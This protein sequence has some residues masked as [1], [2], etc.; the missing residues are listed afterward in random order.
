MKNFKVGKK[1][2]ISY[3]VIMIMLL[4]GFVISIVNLINIRNKVEEFCNGPFVVKSAAHIVN[5]SYESMLRALYRSLTTTDFTVVDE[6]ISEVNKARDTVEEQLNV[7]KKNFSGDQKIVE[8]LS[9]YLRE[10]KPMR[11]HV[12]ELA[13]VNANEEAA[14]YMQENNLIVIQNV[15]EELSKLVKSA[16]ESSDVLL[17]DLRAQQETALGVLSVLGVLSIGISALFAIYITRGV[18]RPIAE[19]EKAAKS[20]SDGELDAVITYDSKD[21]LGR[22]AKSIQITTSRLSVIMAEL[23]QVLKQIAEGN[24]NT[25]FQ[26]EDK[27]VGAFYPLLVSIKQASEELSL[28]MLQ[29]HQSAEQVLSGS[30]QV[31]SG[32]QEL[33]QGT[34]EQ[35]ASVEELAETVNEISEQINYNAENSAKASE[36]AGRVEEEV[37]KSNLRMQEMLEAMREI[38]RSSGEIQKIIKT[39]EDFAF[40]TNILALNASVEASRAGEAGKGFAVVADEVRTL[41]TKS[42]AASK[43]TAALIETSLQAVNA[44][45]QIADET[46]LSLKKVVTGVRNVTS[47][48][49]SVSQ[50]TGDQAASLQ[51]V[52]KGIEQISDVVQTNSATA[53]ESAAASEELSGQAQTLKALIGKFQLIG[54]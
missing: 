10:L 41:A 4:S 34:Y 7:I 36:Q 13:L 37:S 2:V 16:D 29:I 12:V 26:N 38:T 18:T 39:I 17:D 52:T 43:N 45:M 32:A 30:E 28:T 23:D 19:I 24:L 11:E 49:D 27:F 5:T 54:E 22:L 47:A 9:D 33:S 1:L 3:V 53:E 42:A 6:C 44:G 35:A 21:E 48:I 40:Q 46:A 20:I 31:A 51:Q 14:A 50:A 15:Q 8:D 25:A